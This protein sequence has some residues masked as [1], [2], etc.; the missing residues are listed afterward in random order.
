MGAAGLAA[1]LKDPGC[2]KGKKAGLLLCGGNIDPLLLLL[3]LLLLTLTL[4]ASIACGSVRAKRLTRI[5]VS[6]RDVRGSRAR[7]TAT[8]AK[9]GANLDEVH[10]H[11]R[12]LARLAA[13][14]WGMLA[15]R[16]PGISSKASPAPIEPGVC[17]R[18]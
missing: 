12:C 5:I 17:T 16:G 9:A 7:I 2:F 8:V 4:T 10:H 18:R 15:A 14:S 1:L 11:R 13:N 6:V 3:L